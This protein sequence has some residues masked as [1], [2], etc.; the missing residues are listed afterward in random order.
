MSFVIQ[1]ISDYGTELPAVARCVPQVSGLLDVT[2]LSQPRREE[3]LGVVLELQRH[4]LR[5]LAERREVESGVQAGRAQ[6]VDKGIGKPPTYSL[7]GV[8]DLK[9]KCESFLHSARLALHQ[10]GR[11]VTVGLRDEFNDVPDIGHRFDRLLPWCEKSLGQDHLLT[12]MVKNSEPWVALIVRMRNAVDHP[13][14]GNGN[15][16]DV[17]NFRLGQEANSV[18]DPSWRLTGNPPE[19]IVGS[20]LQIE[21]GLLEVYEELFI[22][23]FERIKGMPFMQLVEVPVQDRDP[24]CPIRFR[25]T[26]DHELIKE[27]QAAQAKAARG[28]ISTT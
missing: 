23:V 15:S 16:L 7:P 18:V 22:G 19:A 9:G 13:K 27:M 2:K 5:C 11:V 24:R 8:P 10:C 14:E 6:I 17:L 3:V 20:M 12:Q 4:L 1:K 25:A 28:P 26:V 21:T